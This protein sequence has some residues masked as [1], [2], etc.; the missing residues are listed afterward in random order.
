[1][2]LI[3]LSADK[4][5]NYQSNFKKV[6]LKE[7]R[8]QFNK[9]VVKIYSPRNRISFLW[10][11]ICLLLLPGQNYY[12][13]LTTTLDTGPAKKLAFNLGSGSPI[14]VRKNSYQD[15]YINAKAAVV[16]DAK[17]SMV[18]FEKNPKELFLPASTTKIMTALLALQY[19]H[20]DDVVTVKRADR[21]VGQTM[22]LVQGEQI[23]VEDLLYGLLLHSGNDAAY[24][25]AENYQGGYIAFVEAMND[26]AKKY[27]LEQTKY[28][29]VSGLDQIG[30]YTTAFDLSRL[31]SL[32]MSYPVF[33]KI[34]VTKTKYVSDITG[35]YHH[36]LH[37]INELLS[38]V[39]GIRGVKTGWTEQAGGCLVTD[40]VRE[41]NEIIVV[42]LGSQDRFMDSKNLIEWTYKEHNWVNPHILFP[43]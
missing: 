27:H 4:I 13:T 42:V 40:T 7:Q 24:A 31:T 9:F 33:S 8:K 18:L 37:N 3:S 11:S 26:L 2:K 12:Q 38:E 25:L 15:P 39:T 34:V 10:L 29:N 17:S 6:D 22:N 28:Q 14:P 41:D 36:Y 30:H 16:V 21:S 5:K 20:L 43:N 19:Y 32:A 23:K 35:K 1:M